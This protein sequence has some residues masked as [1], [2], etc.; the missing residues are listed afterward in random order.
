MSQ[1]LSHISFEKACAD[2]FCFDNGT[3][4]K[5]YQA[6]IHISQSKLP[7]SKQLEALM[8]AYSQLLESLPGTQAVFKRYFLSD[9]ANQAEDV[10]VN[11][12]TESLSMT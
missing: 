7:Y 11:D 8:D 5:E 6:M 12:V 4:V 3:E 10:I 2:I 9:A 1:N